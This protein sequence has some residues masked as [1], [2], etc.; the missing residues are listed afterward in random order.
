MGGWVGELSPP[1]P[2]TSTPT[3]VGIGHFW[4]GGSTGNSDDAL[5]KGH[6]PFFDALDVHRGS[7]IPKGSPTGV[8]QPRL[9]ASFTIEL[10]PGPNLVFP[11]LHVTQAIKMMA[12]PKTLVSAK[13]LPNVEGRWWQIAIAVASLACA[14][15]TKMAFVCRAIW[16]KS[17]RRTQKV[18]WRP[19]AKRSVSVAVWHHHM[20]FSF[21]VRK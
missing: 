17:Q 12:S 1:P 16:G 7:G 20:A 5:Q 3:P 21:E 4:V 8:A 13:E 6:C 9:M 10:T 15:H 18:H 19:S 11:N 14:R 2:P